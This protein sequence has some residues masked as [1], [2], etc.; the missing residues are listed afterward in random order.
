MLKLQIPTTN[1]IPECRT[2]L[3]YWSKAK[4]GKAKDV[5]TTQKARIDGKNQI[6]TY[7]GLLQTNGIHRIKVTMVNTPTNGLNSLKVKARAEQGLYGATSINGLA[8]PRN[9]ALIIPIGPEVHPSHHLT[10]GAPPA[11]EVAML[12]AAAMLLRSAFPLKGK[13]NI[14]LKHQ[15]GTRAAR[16]S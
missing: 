3:S 1:P 10:H 12:P 13:E 8:I 4:D 16:R 2:K 6:G 5:E 9:G 14:L 11:I 7:N 15:K